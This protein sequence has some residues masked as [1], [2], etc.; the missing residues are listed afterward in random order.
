MTIFRPLTFVAAFLAAFLFVVP[1][2]PGHAETESDLQFPQPNILRNAQYPCW[3]ND[4]LR[5][6][7]SE[8]GMRVVERALTSPRIDPTK[9]MI[10]IWKGQKYFAILQIYPIRKVMCAILIGETLHGA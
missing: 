3:E 7:F 10:E 4:V 5:R 6:Q 1:A 9:P 2:Q 8:L